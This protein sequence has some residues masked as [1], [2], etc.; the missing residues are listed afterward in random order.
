[1]KRETKGSDVIRFQAPRPGACSHPQDPSLQG[2]S[3]ISPLQ[4][5]YHCG[6]VLIGDRVSIGIIGRWGLS[7]PEASLFAIFQEL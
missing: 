5:R 3:L 2:P 7:G 1:M 4:D 6:V